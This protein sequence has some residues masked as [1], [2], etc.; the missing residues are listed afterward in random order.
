MGLFCRLAIG[1]PFI[2]LCRLCQKRKK[3]LGQ[4]PSDLDRTSLENN[5]FVFREQGLCQFWSFHSLENFYVPLRNSLREL[6]Y[7]TNHAPH[8]QD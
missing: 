6:F 2:Y 4:I 7:N 5:A 1:L 3:K 8:P